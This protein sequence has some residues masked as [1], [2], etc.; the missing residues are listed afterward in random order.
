[1]FGSEGG[2]FMPISVIIRFHDWDDLEKEIVVCRMPVTVYK[3]LI[4]RQYPVY[5]QVNLRKIYKSVCR[6][7]PLYG[8]NFYIENGLIYLFQESGMGI[9]YDIFVL[10]EIRRFFEYHRQIR[11]KLDTMLKSNDLKQ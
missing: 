2:I 1:M 11:K 10:E 6:V 8:I 3:S 7:I 5:D 4:D 9:K